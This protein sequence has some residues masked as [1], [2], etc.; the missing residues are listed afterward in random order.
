MSP[1]RE[2]SI[3]YRGSFILAYNATICCPMI[4]P[5]PRFADLGDNQQPDGIYREYKAYLA[6]FLRVQFGGTCKPARWIGL[7]TLLVLWTSFAHLGNI[8]GYSSHST[9]ILKYSP[10]TSLW[11]QIATIPTSNFGHDDSSGPLSEKIRHALDRLPLRI[12]SLASGPL[13]FP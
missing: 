13:Q 3:T 6:L 12:H 11:D 8:S 5:W 10:R 9:T 2:K 4:C 7:P 1:H